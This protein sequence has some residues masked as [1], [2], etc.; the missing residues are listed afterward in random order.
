MNL[1]IRPNRFFISNIDVRRIFLLNTIPLILSV[2]ILTY[3]LRNLLP[4]IFSSSVKLFG[5][6]ILTVVPFVCSLSFFISVVL[7]LFLYK[8]KSDVFV[9]HFYSL[10]LT[11]KICFLFINSVGLYYYLVFNEI[12]LGLKIVIFLSELYAVFILIVGL[13]KFISYSKRISICVAISLFLLQ[14]VISTQI[15]IFF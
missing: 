7:L 6:L 2:I 15:K 11:F 14:Y 12:N 9:T 13:R 8:F 1:W 10:I 4:G 3:C 5:Y